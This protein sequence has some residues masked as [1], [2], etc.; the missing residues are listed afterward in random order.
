M[1]DASR[2]SR[3]ILFE[4]LG[5]K[6]QGRLGAS[7]A[8]VVGCGAL[9]TRSAE[10]LARAG[11]GRLRLVDRDLVEW[12]NLQRQALFTEEDVRS[13]MPKA[14]AAARHLRGLNS[15]IAVEERVADFTAENAAELIEGADAV[16]D[17]LDNFEGRYLLNDAC[18]SRKIP[19]IY[20]GAVSSYGVT[21]NVVPGKTAC[22]RCVFPEMPP[23]GSPTCDT[24]GVLGPVVA[25]VAA[26]QAMEALKILSGN[27]TVLTASMRTLDMWFNRGQDVEPG[28]P[29]RDCPAC[30]GRYEFLNAPPREMVSLCGQDAMQ[31]RP[32]APGGLDLE[33]LA[34]KLAAAGC[35]ILKNRYLV[36]FHVEG[37]E[38]TVFA[39]GRALVGG[40]H[41]AAR[42]RALYAKYVG[43]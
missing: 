35:G 28:P 17:G 4:P 39:D 20:G 13:A 14:A 12:S 22:L 32:S 25:W 16:L 40:T 37:H 6:G 24:A 26:H 31:V 3:Q 42:A 2:Y 34:G 7:C 30:S 38:M 5:E 10:L 33:A 41:E 9:G 8:V 1:D 23:P 27:E 11:V 29:R 43:T 19:W 36:R 18:L 21:M 15:G